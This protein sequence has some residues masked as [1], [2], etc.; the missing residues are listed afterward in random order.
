ML[1]FELWF[2]RRGNA[3]SLRCLYAKIDASAYAHDASQSP[4]DYA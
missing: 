2:L 3:A 1:D 4:R